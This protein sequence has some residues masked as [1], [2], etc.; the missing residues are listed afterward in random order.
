MSDEFVYWLADKL[1]RRHWT[2]RELA[3]QADVSQSIV[4]KTLSGHVSPSSDFVI[5]V[6]QA[7]GEPPETALRLAGFLP[8][9]PL[10][11]EDRESIRE[12]TELL[13]GMPP[14]MRQ[15]ALRVLRALFR[16]DE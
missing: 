16:G 14:D 2:H 10:T 9:E 6:A 11:A 15:I 3:R 5:K 8:G 12:G 7:L 4:S 1:R 13:R